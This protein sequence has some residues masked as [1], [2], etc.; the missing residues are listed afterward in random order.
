LCR[1]NFCH[2]HRSAHDCACEV[3]AEAASRMKP[4]GPEGLK[5]GTVLGGAGP[6]AKLHSSESVVAPRKPLNERNAALARKARLLR[7]QSKAPLP[8]GADASRFMHLEV[9]YLDTHG[10]S[11]E[12]AERLLN[13][14]PCV[15]PTQY[16]CAD[17]FSTAV[18]KLLDSVA[19]MHGVPNR[20][21]FASDEHLRL[22]MYAIDSSGTVEPA[23]LPFDKLLS[24]LEAD[25]TVESG[26][27]LLLVNGLL[28]AAD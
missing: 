10:T 12:A 25:K 26:S 21:A 14:T 9:A 2:R 7:I 23:C 20:N 19:K 5:A 13:S 15:L 16:C 27:R 4:I 6:T 18:G 28:S 22:H 3:T 1:K 11:L 17:K 24:E 8:K